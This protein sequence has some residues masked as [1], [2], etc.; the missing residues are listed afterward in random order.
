MGFKEWCQ[1]SGLPVWHESG[2]GYNEKSGE[3]YYAYLVSLQPPPPPE[4]G[5]VFWGGEGI[6]TRDGKF[7]KEKKNVT[8]TQDRT[9]QE[10]VYTLDGVFIKKK[11]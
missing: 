9:G 5:V 4:E 3:A 2:S 11:A 7:L 6:Y 8:F 1:K 10:G